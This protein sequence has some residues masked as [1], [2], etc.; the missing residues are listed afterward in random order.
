MSIDPAALCQH[1]KLNGTRC[2][3]PA[4]RNRKFCYFHERYCPVEVDVSISA[5]YPATSF[6]LPVLEDASSIQLAISQVCEHMLHRRLDTKR[7]SVMLYA[8]QVASSNLA[9]MNREQI[10]ENTRQ[11]KQDSVPA[12]SEPSATAQD[13]SGSNTPGDP[14]HLP[15]GTIQA[16]E[17]PRRFVV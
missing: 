1:M 14:E 9:R 10:Q 6:F 17:Q 13:D 2:G 4:L 5:A 11:N 3:S 12:P 15:P 8:M 16:S 7:A